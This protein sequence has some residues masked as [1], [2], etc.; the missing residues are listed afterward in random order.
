[1]TANEPEW[2]T[3]KER[4]DRRLKGLS[5]AWKIVP[6]SDKLKLDTLNGVIVAEFPTSS[7][8]A[9]YGF[10]VAGKLVGFL[11]AKKVRTGAQNV[12][13]QAKRYSRDCTHGI[14]NWNGY[15]APFLYSSNGEKVFFVDVRDPLNIAREIADFHTS[16]A[17]AEML[18]RPDDKQWF[19]KHPVSNS[20]LRKYQGPS[21]E[22]A[23]RL[24][25][26]IRQSRLRDKEQKE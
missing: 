25:E 1:M 24:L 12:L 22:P 7:G 16:D 3:R 13:E 4:I 26:R 9:D 23:E 17:M 10:F 11:E 2:V 15:K 20:R 21:D 14:G 19:K 18:S 5:P 6:W 8:P